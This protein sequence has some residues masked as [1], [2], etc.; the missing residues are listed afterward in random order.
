MKLE[1]DCKGHF[2]TISTARQRKE[3]VSVEDVEN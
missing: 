1:L 2:K 3:S